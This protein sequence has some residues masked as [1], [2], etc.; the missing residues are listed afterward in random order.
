[1]KRQAK[2]VPYMLQLP[3]PLHADIKA[4]AKENRRSMQQYILHLLEEHMR[5]LEEDSVD[6]PHFIPMGLRK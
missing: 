1:M 2:N 6:S 3:A 4:A 5:R